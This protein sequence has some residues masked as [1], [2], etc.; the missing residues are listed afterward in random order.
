MAPTDP[1]DL[2]EHAEQLLAGT[3]VSAETAAWIARSTGDP[4]PGLAASAVEALRAGWANPEL[5]DQ[6][7]DI[8]PE[9]TP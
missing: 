4:G 9:D 7:H 1:P 3:G 2:A 6:A 5:A 8:E